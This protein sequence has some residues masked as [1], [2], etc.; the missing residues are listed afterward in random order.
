MAY[1]NADENVTGPALGASAV[2]GLGPALIEATRA[3]ADPARNA[4]TLHDRWRAQRNGIAVGDPEGGSDH[5]SFLLGFGTPVA[6][7]GLSGPFGPYHSSYDTVRYAT[8]WSDP[9]FVLH[10]TAAQLYGVA[11]MRLADAD[12]LPYAFAAYVPALRSGLL[13]LQARAQR[14]GRRLDLAPVGAAIDAFAA[15]ARRGDDA[16]ARGGGPP[17][18][19]ALAAAQELDRLAYGVNGYASVAYPELDAAYAGRDEAAL[20]A[21]V[22]GAASALARATRLL[23]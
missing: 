17:S 7:L 15:A 2:G 23:R 6:E 22:G 5:A 13:R 11:A 8:T 18:E 9:G 10:R 4:A 20:R 16:I 21:A 3:V 1:L 12:A 14:D 19:R